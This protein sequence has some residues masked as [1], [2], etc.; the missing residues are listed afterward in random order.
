[1]RKLGWE[2]YKLFHKAFS[3]S[4]HKQELCWNGRNPVGQEVKVGG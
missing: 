3:T 1:L 4:V 2:N